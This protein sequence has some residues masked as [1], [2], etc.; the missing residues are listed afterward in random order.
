MK[1]SAHSCVTSKAAFG[2][3][4]AVQ[5]V[6]QQ[7]Y[8]YAYVRNRI[9]KMYHENMVLPWKYTT[10][11]IAPRCWRISH[12]TRALGPIWSYHKLIGGFLALIVHDW[13]GNVL[14]IDELCTLSESKHILSNTPR[15]PSTSINRLCSY[16]IMEDI[17]PSQFSFP[18]LFLYPSNVPRLSYSVIS[19]ITSTEIL[20][21][22]ASCFYRYEIYHLFSPSRRCLLRHLNTGSKRPKRAVQ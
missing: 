13:L 11:W 14:L 6:R 4:S 21:Y 17:Y 8:Y 20:S 15:C 19:K 3:L 9:A 22:P 1:Q 5:R 10:N 2:E 18:I 7:S 16:D 12:L